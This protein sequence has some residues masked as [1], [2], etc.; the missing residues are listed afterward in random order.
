MV[1]VAFEE[2][3]ERVRDER[4]RKAPMA[5]SRPWVDS[6]SAVSEA[7]RVLAGDREVA[8]VDCA[9]SSSSSEVGGYGALTVWWDEQIQSQPVG[10]E[11]STAV[12]MRSGLTSS[13]MLMFLFSLLN[14][15]R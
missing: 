3:T 11:F 1:V 8:S 15:W 12:S 10:Q 5:V 4:E 2:E 6:N 9:C 14:H 13:V 7:V